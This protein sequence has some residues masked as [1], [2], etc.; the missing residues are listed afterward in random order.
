MQDLLD[1]KLIWRKDYAQKFK[2]PANYSFS[3][4]PVCKS[5]YK[6]LAISLI[7]CSHFDCYEGLC[8][9]DGCICTLGTDGGSYSF[10]LD[11]NDGRMEVGI[12]QWT[13]IREFN[14]SSQWFLAHLSGLQRGGP[15]LCWKIVPQNYG[16]HGTLTRTSREQYS[17]LLYDFRGGLINT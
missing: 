15:N 11:F 1:Q 12:L 5:T 10:K 14:W 8:C 2:Q 3:F 9:M 13:L 4:I 17:M 6:L 16:I 7:C